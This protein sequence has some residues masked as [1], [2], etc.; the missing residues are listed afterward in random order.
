MELAQLKEMLSDVVPFNKHIG[1]EVVDVG[2]GRGEVRLPEGTHLLN[3]I[4]T[5]HA[6]ALFAVAEAASGAAVVGALVD[7]I[8]AVTPIARSANIAYL[9]PARGPVTAKAHLSEEPDSLLA[10]LGAQGR[11]DFQVHV[12]L[13]DAQGLKVAEMTVAWYVRKNAST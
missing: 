9:K 11:A 4:G 12:D 2:A 13:E 1:L 10:E 7:Q 5:Q 8:T 3:H 6:A